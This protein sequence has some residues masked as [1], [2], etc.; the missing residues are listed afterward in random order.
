MS[1]VKKPKANKEE[2]EKDEIK[3]NGS[4][5][6]VIKASVKNAKKKSKKKGQ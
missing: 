6:D 5:M 1:K 4:F 2:Q 3:V